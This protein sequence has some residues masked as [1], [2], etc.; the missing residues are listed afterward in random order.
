MSRKLL[1]VKEEGGFPQ[2][3]IDESR[4]TTTRKPP[5]RRLHKQPDKDQAQND[6]MANVLLRGLMNRGL[7]LEGKD[8]KRRLMAVLDGSKAL[9]HAQERRNCLPGMLF[10]SRMALRCGRHRPCRYRPFRRDRRRGC[11][12][13][14]GLA[15]DQLLAWLMLTD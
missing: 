3:R 8:G 1:K 15:G 11:W 2:D 12:R 6:E 14:W 5:L 13:R 9:K 4:G 7:R 10:C